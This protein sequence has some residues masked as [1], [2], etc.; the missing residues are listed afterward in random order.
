MET[1][2]HIAKAQVNI[3]ATVE[4]VWDALVNPD[5]I[6]EYMFGTTVISDWE[7]GGDITWKGE[8]KGAPYKDK[9][10]LISVKP[11][12][13]LE[14]SHSSPMDAKEGNPEFKH[15]VTIELI[16]KD[17]ITNVTLFQDGNPTLEAA[18]HAED[19]WKMMLASLKKVVENS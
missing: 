7:E 6:K 1:Q 9:G 19:N 3:E 4:E 8:W 16:P 11:N 14:Y 5:K 17:Q 2:N 13:L 12:E 18:I 15:K 10:T